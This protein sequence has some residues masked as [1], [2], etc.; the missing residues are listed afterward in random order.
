LGADEWLLTALLLPIFQPDGRSLKGEFWGLKTG[1]PETAAS[2]IIIGLGFRA[3]CAEA[4]CRNLAR[5][6]FRHADAGGRSMTNLMLCHAHERDRIE[7]NRAAGLKVY[8]DREA[9]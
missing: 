9:S 8:D 5:L 4:G 3:P 6:G 1:H 7:R 2:V